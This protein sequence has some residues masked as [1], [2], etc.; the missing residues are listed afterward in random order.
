MS[1]IDV[2]AVTGTFANKRELTK[3]LTAALMR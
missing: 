2:Y 3:D 1:M